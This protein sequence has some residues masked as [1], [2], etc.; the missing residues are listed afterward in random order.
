MREWLPTVHSLTNHPDTRSR[1]TNH[2][3]TFHS[4]QSAM[5]TLV[6]P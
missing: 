5:N 6:S 4:T 1:I 2:V 3:F